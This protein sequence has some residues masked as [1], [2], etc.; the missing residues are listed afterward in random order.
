MSY[1]KV[2]V[3][4]SRT[5]IKYPIKIN[6]NTFVKSIGIFSTITKGKNSK[7][8]EIKNMTRNENNIWVV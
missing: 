8:N 4:A 5:L 2:L 1:F 7:I 3:Y 6:I